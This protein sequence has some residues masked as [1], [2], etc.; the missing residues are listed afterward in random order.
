M[1]KARLKDIYTKEIVPALC[2][3][4]GYRNVMAAPK[5][6]KVVVNMGVG[7]AIQNPKVLDFAC[8]DLS[9]ITGQKPVVTR[10]KNQLPALN[11]GREWQ[12]DAG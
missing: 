12:L 4:M 10:A 1:I 3:E 2:Q 6:T 7:E 9:K 11:C 8:K 5:I